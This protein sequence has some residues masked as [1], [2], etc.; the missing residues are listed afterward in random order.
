[1]FIGGQRNG[2]AERVFA[3]FAQT[4]IATARPLYAADPLGVDLD[5]S[6]YALDSTTID[7]CLT[8]FP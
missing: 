2:A 1:M 8:L 6:L 5:H 7:L 3:A 4:L